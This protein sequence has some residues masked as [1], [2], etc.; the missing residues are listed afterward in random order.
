MTKS[1]KKDKYNYVALKN[2]HHLPF[3]KK[4]KYSVAQTPLLGCCCRNTPQGGGWVFG[5][6]KLAL[7]KNDF[8][9][10]PF[11]PFFL[12]FARLKLIKTRLRSS[13]S[14]ERLDDLLICESDIFVAN[15]MV[16]D[17]SAGN[18]KVLQSML[19]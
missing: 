14:E 3:L 18:S 17:E 12:K 16:I 2:T 15:D 7:H 19:L 9:Q 6:L 10:I 5:R 1:L 8:C 11:K 4:N 13:M